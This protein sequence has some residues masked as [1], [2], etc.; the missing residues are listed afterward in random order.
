[1]FNMKKQRLIVFTENGAR[2]IKDPKMIEELKNS[3]GAILNPEELPTK[4]SPSFWK[5]VDGDIE[6]CKDSEISKIVEINSV[7]SLHEKVKIIKDFNNIQ[8]LNKFKLA[9]F[10]SFLLNVCLI[11]KV[12]V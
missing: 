7:S 5:N 1:M 2:I 4:G 6:L 12:L 11:I 3:K 10:A 9:L 8:K